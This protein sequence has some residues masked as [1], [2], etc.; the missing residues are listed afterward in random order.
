M[1][2][3][4]VIDNEGVIR[5]ISISRNCARI[6]LSVVRLVVTA[7]LAAAAILSTPIAAAAPND[8]RGV[9]NTAEPK[10][11]GKPVDPNG[12]GAI[13]SQRASSVHDIGTH[14]S[15]Q[16]TPHLGVGNVA[17]HDQDMAD[18]SG[19][20]NTGTRPGDHA[21]AIYRLFGDPNVDPDLPPGRPR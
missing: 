6:A 18:A 11:T 10:S 8:N 15:Q 19:T 9:P 2:K 4:L 7:G 17:R 14:V 13:T 5:Y 20:P 16:P 3:Q 21:E 12:F 1:K